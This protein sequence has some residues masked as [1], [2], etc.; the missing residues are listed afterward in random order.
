[1]SQ[2][3]LIIDLLGTPTDDIWPG[4]SSLPIMANINLRDQPF[5][6]LKRRFTSLSENGLRL[7]NFLFMYDPRQ[8]ATAAE[9]LQSSFF[10]ENPRPCEPSSIHLPGS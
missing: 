6:N 10:R 2:I 8:R 5:N 1:M 4:L 7:M 3:N 9:C